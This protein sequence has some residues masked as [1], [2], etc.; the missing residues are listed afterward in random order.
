M[1]CIHLL[2]D[3]CADS[4]FWLLQ[5]KL[6][7]TFGS[8]F[9]C[10]C[11]FSFLCINVQECNGWIIRCVECLVLSET[12]VAVPFLVYW[13][14]ANEWPSFS[15]S[16]QAFGLVIFYFS[17]SDSSVVVS[18]CGFNCISPMASF[19][20]TSFYVFICHFYILFCEMSVVFSFSSWIV[21][22]FKC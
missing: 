20:W 12:G 10:E 18:H 3:L 22:I 15:I 5:I 11:V 1:V 21:A 7:W 16:I 13:P 9:S 8:R 2:K 4:S 19:C 14:V 6:L 17:H